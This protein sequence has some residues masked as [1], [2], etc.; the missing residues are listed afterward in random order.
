[1]YSYWVLNLPSC[2]HESNSGNYK[3]ETVKILVVIRNFVISYVYLALDNKYSI[4]KVENMY[5]FSGETH[6]N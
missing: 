5:D 2:T 1:M 3:N 6:E 4:N